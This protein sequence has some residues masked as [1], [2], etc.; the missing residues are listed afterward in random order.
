MSTPTLDE[1]LSALV[2]AAQLHPQDS[3]EYRANAIRAHVAAIEAVRDISRAACRTMTEYT[4][5]RE[6]REGPL[7]DQ[8]A[9]ERCA[10]RQAQ[11]ANKDLAIEANQRISGVIGVVDALYVAANLPQYEEDRKAELAPFL[12]ALKTQQERIKELEAKLR[13]FDW[14]PASDPP[15]VAYVVDVWLEQHPIDAILPMRGWYE[16]GEWRVNYARTPET[17]FKVTH[18]RDVPLPP[19]EFQVD[20]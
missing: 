4:I 8:I 2:V 1:L 20:G 7:L 3:V 13:E 18:W 10:R 9:R 19:K 15:K 5:D 12:E 11:R 17:P 14:H 16:W 6:W